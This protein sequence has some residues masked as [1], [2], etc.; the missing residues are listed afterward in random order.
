MPTK[1]TVL[2]KGISQ[3]YSTDTEGKPKVNLTLK[4]E[5]K[6]GVKKVSDLSKLI[7][8]PVYLE[9]EELQPGLIDG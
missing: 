3:T 5:V 8:K 4:L 7:N 1:I 6:E 2:V 9:V